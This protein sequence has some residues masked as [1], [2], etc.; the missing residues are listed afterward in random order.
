MRCSFNYLCLIVG[1]TSL[2]GCGETPAPAAAKPAPANVAQTPA[3]PTDS[4]QPAPTA[5]AAAPAAAESTPATPAATAQPA[6]QAEVTR[7]EAAEA[8]AA[9]PAEPSTATA[10]LAVMNLDSFPK[11]NV[12][13]QF[14]SNPS[15]VYYSSEGTIT[16]ADKSLMSELKT[17]GWQEAK[18]LVSSTDQYVDRLLSKNGYYLRLTISTGSTAGELA[19]NMIQL[20]NFDMRL[21]PKTKDAEPQESTA[22][23]AGH[24]SKL[25]IPEA[26]DDLSKRMMDEGWQVVQDFNAPMADVPHY[27]SIR[28]RKNAICVNLGLV[29]DPTKPDRLNIFYHAEAVMPIDIP[30]IDHRQPL[31]YDAMQ[32]RASIPWTGDRTK[33]VELLSQRATDYG[34]KLVNA[35]DYTQEKTSVLYISVGSPIGIA[36]RYVESGGK[37][38]ISMERVKLPTK[39]EPSSTVAPADQVAA[40]ADPAPNPAA[41]K[42]KAE[43]EAQFEQT[44]NAINKAVNDELAKALGSLSGGSNKPDMKALQAQAAQ[45][46]AQF[47]GQD[48]KPEAPSA[49]KAK[50]PIN[51]LDVPD[52]QE[53]ISQEDQAISATEAKVKLGNREVVLKHVAAYAR[54]EDDQPTKIL[55]FSSGPMVTAKLDKLCFSG[56]DFSIYSGFDGPPADVV[57]ELRIAGNQV[58]MNFAADGNSLSTNTSDLK[59]TVR[60]HNGKLQGRVKLDKPMELRKQSFDL[61]VKVKESVRK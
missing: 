30:M 18:H 45:L 7:I 4:T 48:E 13:Q 42:M 19:I 60:L 23:M 49:A 14:D 44:E 38:S 5:P 32:V 29:K 36:T 9:K 27:R 6:P 21:L 61:D 24:Y 59:S 47:G 2:S 16:S 53:P 51:G 50:K 10:A 39:K 22:V 52:D 58:N 28:F 3:A 33:L 31:K 55:L 57:L 15:S 1:L 40:N 17:A 8:P 35:D 54:I 46:Q 12:K 37:Y 34:W 20:G 43:I 25:T 41:Q 56:Q 11:L 26:Y